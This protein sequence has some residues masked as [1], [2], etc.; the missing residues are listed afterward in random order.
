MDQALTSDEIEGVGYRDLAHD[1]FELS[2]DMLA[3]AGTDG[4][5]KLLNSSWERTL[6]HS[7]GVLLAKPYID[8]VH[9][10]DREA[11]IREGSQLASG[12]P[13]VSFE[14]RY[15]CA[16]GS[17]KWLLWKATPREGS[18][19]IFAVARDITDRKRH[20]QALID[21]N[22]LLTGR[23]NEQ[24]EELEDTVESLEQS[25]AALQGLASNL[26]GMV[27][28]C[29]NDVD[30]TMMYI[31]HGVEELTGY[32]EAALIDNTA[33]SY[34][35]LIEPD[36]RTM[37]A[38][39]VD[40]SL[41]HNNQFETEY[42]IR[43]ASGEQKWVWEQ[44]RA[45]YREDGELL[46]LEGLILDVTE[47]RRAE[48]LVRDQAALLDEARDAILVRDVEG[49]IVFWNKGAER[50][51]GW[52]ADEV[53]GKPAAD[54]LARGSSQSR[55]AMTET[56]EKGLWSGELK[57]R[58]KDGKDILVE[59]RWSLLRSETGEAR[60]ALTIATD[61]TDRKRLE[62]QLL[63]AQRLESVGTLA[64]GIAHDLNNALTPVLMGV[65]MLRRK[66][67]SG[68]QRTLEMLETSAQRGANLVKQV[69]TF[70]RGM[71]GEPIPLDL[72]HAVKEFQKVADQIFPKSIRVKVDI[73]EGVWTVSADP[74][75]IDQILMNL[76]VNARD[77]MP[78]GGTL[79]IRTC[80]VSVD[81]AYARMCPDAN[82][83]SYVL[84]EVND[85]G[86]GMPKEIAERVFEPF[87]TTKE[88]GKGT[89]LGL[90]TVHTIIRNHGGFANVY[91]EV[92]RGTTFRVYI[93]ATEG[94]KAEL[95]PTARVAAPGRGQTI[96]V[97]DDEDLI[98]EMVTSL[99]EEAGY[100][101][102]CVKNGAEAVAR[103][104]Q[105]GVDVVIMDWEMPVMNGRQTVQAIR[106]IDSGARII[107]SSGM[108]HADEINSLDIP[109]PFL[110]K[111]YTGEVLL[112]KLAEL[113]GE[114]TEDES[115]PS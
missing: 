114:S 68:D 70:G 21:I 93:P 17:Y 16:D 2:L 74:T 77:A 30:W 51:F 89:G 64:S 19:H 62:A 44:G 14:N 10:D 48:Q 47:R 115:G 32:T 67:G 110:P 80:N 76:G 40:S 11:T 112:T 45:V 37:V 104:A 66:S 15:R 38:E 90:S 103:Y 87:F 71:A 6:G 13:S 24:S 3:V 108:P 79:T 27:Y 58:T 73:P 33:I 102:I 56:L 41:A 100:K 101:S 85:T 36:D 28:R 98:R 75:Q 69:L 92:G 54:V 52:Q 59:S 34:A 31:S 42:R 96:M 105:G 86:Q 107:A 23:F 81:T 49:R 109:V 113:A 22:N 106:N 60:G 8:F 18:Q 99:L 1:F 50:I 53:L 9:P 65:Q 95:Q 91:S 35:D 43:T 7:I 63:R 84:V 82:P 39:I 25:R 111:P 78:D 55:A 57:E 20:E 61:I 97:V 12:I 26:P 4:Y 29:R 94:V 46:Y 5:F 83:G 88:V 72:S